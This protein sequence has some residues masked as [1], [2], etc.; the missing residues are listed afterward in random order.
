MSTK[1]S[2]TINDA[3]G[4]GKNNEYDGSYKQFFSHPEMVKSLIR[5]FVPEKW[6][7]GLDF[8]TLE[9]VNKSFSC[10]DI[11]SRH[12][13]C[14]WRVKWDDS[15]VY[16]YLL[17][18]FQSTVDPWMA[19][20]IMVY[21]G[22]LYQ[23]LIKSKIVG[24]GDKLP[25]VFPIVL[26]NG[27]NRWSAKQE[28]SDLITPMPP[29]LAR[30]KPNQRYF[31][32]DES[33]VP[34]EKLNKNEGLSTLLISLEQVRSTD[35]LQCALKELMK[36][37]KGPEYLSLRRIFT[38]FIRRIVLGRMMPGEPIPEVDDLQEVDN[39]LAERVTEWTEKWKSEGK[40]EGKQEGKIEGTI[41]TAQ[42]MLLKTLRM[43]FG[44]VKP[45]VASRVNSIHSQES[46][47]KL[48]ERAFS[49]AS[50]EEFEKDLTSATDN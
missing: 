36:R 37:L 43:K 20:R 12:D 28:I 48:F 45:M 39:M 38:V 16:V 26:Y 29:S 32:L 27:C 30:Y 10:D 50:L 3:S 4:S 35:E 11:R 47:D 46:L 22:L 40:V 17:I 14:I 31:F 34:K 15:W 23:D 18:E 44:T 21:T 9:N 24:N 7:R 1:K 13:D 19:V 5:D 8:S 49:C 6:V 25:P 2:K 33:S 41:E 42:K